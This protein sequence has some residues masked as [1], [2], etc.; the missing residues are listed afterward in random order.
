LDYSLAD[1]NQLNG[2][3]G[4]RKIGKSCEHPST[5]T[6]NDDPASDPQRS[7]AKITHTKQLQHR[8]NAKMALGHFI[9]TNSLS[10]DT[11]FFLAQIRSPNSNNNKTNT[12]SSQN[13]ILCTRMT[14][15]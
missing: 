8:V 11:H 13:G 9:F 4:S 1:A 15:K 5:Q 14:S 12:W 2:E 10:I 3:P 6:T 7:F